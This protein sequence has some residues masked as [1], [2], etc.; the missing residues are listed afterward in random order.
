MIYDS[1]FNN[2]KATENSAGIYIEFSTKLLL[3]NTTL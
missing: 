2:N 3:E 1:D